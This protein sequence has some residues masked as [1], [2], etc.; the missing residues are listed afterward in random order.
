M[1]AVLQQAPAGTWKSDP[2]HSSVGFAVRHMGIATFRGTFADYDV[3]LTGGEDARISGAVR[4][5]SVEVK[6]ENL[7]A[8]L[9]SP[10][11]FDAQRHP[12]LRFESTKVE[13]GDGGDLL[14]E[15]DLT[16]KGTTKRV[17]G[18]GSLTQPGPDLYGNE[19][20]GLSLETVVDRTEFGLN[21][22]Q[23]LPSGGFA[24]S[25]DV[26]LVIDLSLV[27]EA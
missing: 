20:V 22:N 14:V 17:S 26:K 7:E 25:N 18:R 5:A 9:G 13:I 12:E 1:S 15:G 19:R 8:H 23:P 10:D 21:W 2:V 27:K 3:T 4:V 11:F 24:V 16:I 6:D